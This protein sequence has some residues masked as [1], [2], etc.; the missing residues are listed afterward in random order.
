MSDAVKPPTGEPAR[1]L[2][3][4]T[5]AHPVSEEDRGK[6]PKIADAWLRWGRENGYQW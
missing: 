1:K 4:I 2:S 3:A 5:G 6:I